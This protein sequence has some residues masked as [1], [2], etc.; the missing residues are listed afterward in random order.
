MMMSTR[1]CRGRRWSEEDDNLLRSMASAGKSVTL[2]TVKL[3]RPMSS[4]RSRAKDLSVNLPGTEIGERRKRKRSAG[5]I[6]CAKISS[7]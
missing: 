4:I 2:M 1:E 6:P 7:E 5:G 3:N